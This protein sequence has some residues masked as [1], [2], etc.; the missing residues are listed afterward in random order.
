MH[1]NRVLASDLGLSVNQ[2]A[3]VIRPL[4]AGDDVTTWQDD[5]GET[6]DVNLRLTE[7]ARSLPSDVQNLYLTSQKNRCQWSSFIDSPF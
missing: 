4:I 2:I 6:Y 3:N 7:N 1:I 5:K